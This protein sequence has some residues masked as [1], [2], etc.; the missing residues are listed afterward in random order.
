MHN[1]LISKVEGISLEKIKVSITEDDPIINLDLYEILSEAGFLV[2]SR[3]HNVQSALKELKDTPPDVMVVDIRLADNQNGIDLVTS[4]RKKYPEL[5]VVFLTGSSDERIKRSA[6]DTSPSAFLNKP[7]NENNLILAIE[8]A[9]DRGIK[10]FSIENNHKDFVLIKSGKKI[11]KLSVSSIQY[12]K[13]EGSYS[14]I[15]TRDDCF[16]QSGNLLHFENILKG[17]CIRIHKSYLVNKNK[18]DSIST[19][20]VYVNNTDIPIGRRFKDELITFWKSEGKVL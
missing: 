7:F 9:A 13:A 3:T 12:I 1:S 6:F 4:M 2:V 17:R 18:I 8:L 19:N 11:E 20:T 10:N 16:I 5:P 15:F 14:K